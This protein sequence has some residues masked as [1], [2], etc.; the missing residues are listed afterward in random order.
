MYNKLKNIIPNR[1]K[2]ENYSAR[3]L[4]END[5]PMV[6][7]FFEDNKDYF[8]LTGSSG[9]EPN[10]AEQMLNELPEGKSKDDKFWIGLFDNEK[11]ISFIDVVQNYKSEGEWIIGHYIIDINYRHKSIGSKLLNSLE[12][13]LISL[14]ANGLRV[15]VQEQ[16]EAGFS[17]WTKMGFSEILRTK[18]EVFKDKDNIIVMTKK[19]E[20]KE[21]SIEEKFFKNG[22]LVNFPSKPNEQK[23]IY[24]IMKNW[25][26]EG[27]EYTEPQ[28]NEIIKSK[29]ECRDHT[30]LRRDLV[31]N[32]ILKRS[33]NGSKYW[34]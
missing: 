10:E 32:G 5:L 30:T 17:F 23:D 1:I 16:N 29:I 8:I 28:I 20:R 26:E 33:D 18:Q 7:T 11:I 15:V 27:K 9:P 3:L 4:S 6:Q 21:P 31:D 12:N 24:K 22:K 13:I 19:L 25:F 34:I 14:K 2:I